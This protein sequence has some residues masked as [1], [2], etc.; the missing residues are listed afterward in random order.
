MGGSPEV[1]ISLA[2]MVKSHLKKIVML[3]IKI[4]LTFL[5]LFAEFILTFRLYFSETNNE[6]RFH[7]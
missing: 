3:F 4:K 6:L 7:K 1:G 2:N 5:I